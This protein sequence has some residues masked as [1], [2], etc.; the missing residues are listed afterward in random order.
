[1][2]ASPDVRVLVDKV[3]SATKKPIGR[4][5]WV[6]EHREGDHR[7]LYPLLVEG[8]V[9]DARLTII[10]YP[11]VRELQFRLILSY[12]RAIWRLDFSNDETHVNS[13]NRPD[14]LD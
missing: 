6:D 8:E 13:F 14:D 9:S 4:A 3:L 12:G 11:R 7:L 10:A 1:M 2:P 5:E